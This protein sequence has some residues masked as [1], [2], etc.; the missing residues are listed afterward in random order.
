M[1]LPDDLKDWREKNGFVLFTSDE[2][3]FLL[4]LLLASVIGYDVI[5]RL[6]ERVA[7]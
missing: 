2:S 4:L 1:E 3:L 6:L 7:A 5:C